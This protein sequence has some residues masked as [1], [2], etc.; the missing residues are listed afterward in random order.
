MVKLTVD[1]MKK[2]HEEL[3]D[4]FERKNAD[5]G[6]SFEES[7]D[8][9]GLIAAIVRMEDKMSRISKLSETYAVQMVHDESIIDT[10]KDLSNYALMAAV[11][12]EQQ[13]KLDEDGL[14]YLEDCNPLLKEFIYDLMEYNEAYIIDRSIEVI[15]SETI[16][17]KTRYAQFQPFYN[18]FNKY[19]FK[20]PNYVL[21]YNMNIEEGTYTNTISIF[22]NKGKDV[23]IKS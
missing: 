14:L 23:E 4:I 8:K 2:A 19:N 17:F 9:H 7:L 12:F 22:K 18:W 10:L 5:Y 20:K 1:N 15:D 6:N 3:Q 13:E 21:T 11:W 16:S